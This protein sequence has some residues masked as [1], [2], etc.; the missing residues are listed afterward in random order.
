MD[1]VRDALGLPSVVVFPEGDEMIVASDEML[2]SL[3]GRR[4]IDFELAARRLEAMHAAFERAR[5]ALPPD[6]AE[7]AAALERAYAG[8]SSRPGLLQRIRR[9][10]GGALESFLERLF[11]TGGFGTF[12]AWAVVAALLLAGVWGLTR[13]VVPE[14]RVRKGAARKP[15]A[16]DWRRLSAEALAR[17]D[18]P[19]AVRAHYQLLLQALASKGIVRDSPTLTAGECRSSVEGARPSLV[20][21]VDRATGVFERVAYGEQNLLPGDLE[22]M[23]RAE[24]EVR[25][26]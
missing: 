10:I 26:R 8:V 16:V 9:W 1:A 12:V 22:A 6:R 24:E 7:V 13:A 5:G 20:P 17:G 2:A 11:S 21:A 23:Q 25:S 18:T 14:R 4:G 19:E 15:E 3:A